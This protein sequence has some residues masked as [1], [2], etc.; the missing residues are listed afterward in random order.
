M[1]RMI[2]GRVIRCERSQTSALVASRNSSALTNAKLI[3]EAARRERI[4]EQFRQS[5]KM[6]TV[7]QLTGVIAHDFNNM[8][9]IIIGSLNYPEASTTPW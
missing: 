6:E 2:L 1:I 5:Q 8:L 3:E 9:A 7:G 4:E